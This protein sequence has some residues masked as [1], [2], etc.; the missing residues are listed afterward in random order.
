LAEKDKKNDRVS[1][2]SLFWLY[3]KITPMNRTLAKCKQKTHSPTQ[4]MPQAFFVSGPGNRAIGQSG[5]R[6]IG[7]SGNRAIGQLYTSLK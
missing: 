7:Q 4:K 5:N 2:L 3:V 1:P 6:A